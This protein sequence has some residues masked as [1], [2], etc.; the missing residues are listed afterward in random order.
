MDVRDTVQA[1]QVSTGGIPGEM[2][3]SGVLNAQEIG[4]ARLFSARPADFMG[5]IGL[6]NG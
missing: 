2:T 1:G 6:R 5:K 3:G 4:H